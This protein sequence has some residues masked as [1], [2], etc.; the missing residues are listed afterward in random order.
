[1][2]Q[3]M[4]TYKFSVSFRN[5]NY[6]EV[7]S[8]DMPYG[9]WLETYTDYQLR[10]KSIFWS[11]VDELNGKH[12]LFGCIESLEQSNEVGFPWLVKSNKSKIFLSWVE[13]K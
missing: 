3:S 13:V 8:L 12:C 7:Y 1:M 5:I 10:D 6:S 9:E 11:D 2:V 4:K